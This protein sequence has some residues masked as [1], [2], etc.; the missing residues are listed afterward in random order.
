[1]PGVVHILRTYGPH[2]GEQQLHRMFANVAPDW[3]EHF[4]YVYRDD[5]CERLFSD[6]IHLKRATLV[7]LPIRPSQSPWIEFLILLLFLPI[8]QFRFFR[9]LSKTG[10]Q[11]CIVHGFQAA[12]IAWPALWLKP[13]LN[14]AYVHRTTKTKPRRLIRGIFRLMYRPFRIIV[15]VSYAV[16]DSLRQFVSPDRV[17]V[18]ANGIDWKQIAEASDLC[19]NN[20]NKAPGDLILISVGRLHARKRHD[21]IIQ[22]FAMLRNE[23]PTA[24]LWLVGEGDF[25]GT[26]E[27]VAYKLGL[28]NSVRWLGMRDDVSC[29]L[30]E[31]DIYVH[32]SAVEGLS[33]AVLEAMAA[34]L[35]SV[36]VDA[37]GVTECHEPGITGFVVERSVRAVFVGLMTL[38]GDPELRERM[39]MAARE[40]V[41]NHYSIEANRL[42][43]LQLYEKLG[44]LN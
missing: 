44:A 41:K 26:L 42:R 3:E 33:N 24:K 27:G 25:R 23:Y 11:I 38:A 14:A 28:E 21:L 13:A 22:A 2:G 31:S 5:A 10:C 6:L 43:Y 36:V 8:A 35:P 1:M 15:G 37:P 12:L 40:R 34:G 30:G 19:R 39:G 20:R 29:L 18:L 4:L 7:P 17:V 32:A 16:A 9:Y